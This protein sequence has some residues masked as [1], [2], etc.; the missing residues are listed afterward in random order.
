MG[1]IEVPPKDLET[2]RKILDLH[3]PGIEVRAF[4]SRV[5]GNAR[6]Y[7]DLDLILMTDEALEIRILARLNAALSE[8]SLPFAVDVLDWAS[9]EESFRDLVSKDSVVIRDRNP[10]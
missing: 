3:V 5:A 10:R 6:R 8:S 2:I 1:R 9:L 7:S 4:G